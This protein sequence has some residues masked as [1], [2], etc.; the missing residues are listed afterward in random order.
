MAKGYNLRGINLATK[1]E[2]QNSNRQTN[3]K[4]TGGRGRHTDRIMN[5]DKA[6]KMG[7]VFTVPLPRTSIKDGPNS[8]KRCQTDNSFLAQNNGDEKRL[9]LAAFHRGRGK[10]TFRVAFCCKQH[11][12]RA[13]RLSE[14]GSPHCDRRK[15]TKPYA[16]R[17]GQTTFASIVATSIAPTREASVDKGYDD[18]AEW[19]KSARTKDTTTE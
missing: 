13:R 12:F 10:Q 18:G 9:S 4:N 6:E 2:K 7:G 3:K 14:W 17:S 15:H 11:C 19:G 8:A 5:N 1:K 16:A